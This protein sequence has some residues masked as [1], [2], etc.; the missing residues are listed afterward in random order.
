MQAFEYLAV[1][2]SIVLGLGITQLLSAFARQLEQ[3]RTVKSYAPA[4]GWA[5]FLL[6]VH[7]QT[8]WSMFGLRAWDEWN[9]LQFVMVLLQPIVLFLLATLAMP[10]PA[11]TETDLKANFFAHRTWFFGLLLALIVVSLAKDMVRMG[12][13]PEPANLAFHGALFTTFA[14]GLLTKSDWAHRA[15][16]AAAVLLMAV[17]TLSLF[18]DLA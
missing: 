2:I 14:V 7:I 5:V 3:R 13:L 6:L 4:L 10:G 8:W 1:L 15:L 9:F 17:Y 18:A 12:R 16:A 11:S